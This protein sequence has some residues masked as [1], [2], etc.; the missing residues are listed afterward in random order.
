MLAP[1]L[2]AV[3]IVAHEPGPAVVV[4]HL[5]SPS[6][7]S[8]P[9]A[10]RFRLLPFAKVVWYNFC[11]LEARICRHAMFCTPTGLAFFGWGENTKGQDEESQRGLWPF[12]KAYYNALMRSIDVAMFFQIL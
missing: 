3:T 11:V 7:V 9:V 12:G 10:R 1:F 2:L 8:R 5:D 6:R 4:L